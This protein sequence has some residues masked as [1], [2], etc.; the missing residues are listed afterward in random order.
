MI[1][2]TIILILNT[3]NINNNN[4]DKKKKKKMMKY[5]QKLTPKH[6]LL[7]TYRR[8]ICLKCLASTDQM[9]FNFEELVAKVN[10]SITIANMANT[11]RAI[12]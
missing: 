1:M 4:N 9:P 5:T 12:H 11:V 7:R 3:K 10:T 6:K 8:L 2:T